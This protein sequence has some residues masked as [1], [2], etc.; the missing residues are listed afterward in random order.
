MEGR[1]RGTQGKEKK[2]IRGRKLAEWKGNENKRAEAQ[3]RKRGM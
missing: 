1:K 3:G 2:G